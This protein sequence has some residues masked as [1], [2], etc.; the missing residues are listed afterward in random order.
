MTGQNKPAPR[1]A[2]AEGEARDDCNI[3]SFGEREDAKQVDFA[4]TH[5]AMRCHLS[6]SLARVAAT[7]ANLAR[8]LA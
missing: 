4:V 5:V 1:D 8:G 6:L 3:R 7:L 2:D